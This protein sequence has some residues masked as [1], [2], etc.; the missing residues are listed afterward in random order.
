MRDTLTA[1]VCLTLCV[2]VGVSGC[3]LLPKVEDQPVISLDQKRF[4]VNN[5]TFSLEG[6]LMDPG[7]H[8]G[9]TFR[10]ITVYLYSANES[11]ILAKQ[12]GTMELNEGPDKLPRVSVESDRIPEYIIF[13]SPDFWGTAGVEYYERNEQGEFGPAKI[14]YNRSDLPVVPPPATP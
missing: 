5:S 8:T 10:N 9:Y 2:A 1:I 14:V 3:S 13:D 12:V 11:L 6:R 7:P 4:E